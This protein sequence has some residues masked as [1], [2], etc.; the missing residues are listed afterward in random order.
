MIKEGIL[1]KTSGCDPLS[2][3]IQ[4]HNKDSLEILEE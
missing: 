1:V 3:A 4:K 2:E